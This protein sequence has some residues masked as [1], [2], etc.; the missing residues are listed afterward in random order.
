MTSRPLQFDGW[1]LTLG[2]AADELVRWSRG[3]TSLAQA[4]RAGDTVAAH[5][6]WVCGSLDGDD[7]ADLEEATVATL[8]TVNTARRSDQSLSRNA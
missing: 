3:G 1:A 6:D 7:V 4:P 5:W 8:G 2:D